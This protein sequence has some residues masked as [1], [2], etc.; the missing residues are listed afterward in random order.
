MFPLRERKLI[1]GCKA[2]KNAGL[3][4]GADYEADYVELYA[5]FD[6]RDD[7]WEGKQGGNWIS[8]LRNNGDVIQ[9]AHLDK[10]KAGGMVKEGDL[11]AI[12]GNTGEIT[13]GPH[14]HIQIKDKFGNRLDP[15]DY[16]WDGE[17][18]WKAIVNMLD[19]VDKR[20]LNLGYRGILRRD[21]DK[22][23][24][25]YL[26]MNKYEF[27]EILIKSEEFK[28]YNPIFEKIKKLENW[29]RLKLK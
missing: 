15:E 11:I 4:C 13:T 21:P 7:I 28:I 19:I 29:A 2:H 1:R 20:F 27:M 9:F 24:E 6:G 10:Y 12:T 16:D 8:F 23:A 22:D 17:E 18:I 5:P 14:L 25:G 26:G 3:G